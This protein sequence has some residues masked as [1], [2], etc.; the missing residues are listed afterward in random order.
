MAMRRW[1]ELMLVLLLVSVIVPT[2]PRLFQQMRLAGELL[3]L[4]MHAR[5]ERLMPDFYAAIEKIRAQVPLSERIALVGISRP[6]L[7]AALFVNYYLYP[8]PT[9][10]FR[11]RWAYLVAKAKPKVLVG[12]GNAPRVMT[13]AELRNEDVRS[14]RILSVIW[15]PPE[16][17]TAFAIPMVTSTDGPR[18]VAYTIEGALAADDEAHVTL[19]L[20]P[21]RIAKQLTIRGSLTFSDLVYECFAVTEF[22]AWV[23]VS[24][25]KPI[26]AAFWLVNRGARTAAPI[27][28][29]EGPLTKPTPF[30]EMPGASLWLLN[31]SDDF[32]VAHA[33]SHPALVLG[34]TLMA[35]NATG[36]VTGRVYAFIS[37]KEPNGQTRIIWPEDL[38]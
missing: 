24:S 11:D 29:V 37:I 1:R 8:H 19:T 4:S 38:R 13:Y 26:H 33:G 10:I 17:R 18:P 5:R 22:A 25:D 2:V 3:P 6:S 21:A 23:D 27:R 16:A 30:P 20:Y 35:I 9:K 12:L 15:L 32:T 28:L 14:S 36:T 31:L 34:R 7:D